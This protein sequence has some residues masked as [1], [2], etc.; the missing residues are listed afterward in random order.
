M[1][2]ETENWRIAEMLTI[3]NCQGTGMEW[4]KERPGIIKT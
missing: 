2:A 3:Q 4:M 1:E